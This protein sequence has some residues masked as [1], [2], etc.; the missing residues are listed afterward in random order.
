MAYRIFKQCVPTLRSQLH[1]ARYHDYVRVAVP[2]MVDHH[3][4]WYIQFINQL[5]WHRESP[6]FIS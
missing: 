6:S 4:L 5:R 1:V 2:G 3:F